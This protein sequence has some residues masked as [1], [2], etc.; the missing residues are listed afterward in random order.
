M[1]IILEVMKMIIMKKMIM[2]TT[3]MHVV[4]YYNSKIV[5]QLVLPVEVVQAAST[6]VQYFLEVLVRG[7]L[8]LIA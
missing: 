5:Q 8:L 1:I 7:Y 6:P 2:M 3:T 4:L